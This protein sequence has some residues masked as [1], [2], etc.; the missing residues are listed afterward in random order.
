MKKQ[1]KWLAVVICFA[2]L[3]VGAIG[4][5]QWWQHTYVP[6]KIENLIIDSDVAFD[7]SNIRECV[8]AVDYLF[9][10][11]VEKA[12]D[13]MQTKT[14]REWPKYLVELDGPCTEYQLK[15]V[16]NI[17]GTLRQDEP[18]TY[19]QQ[20]GISA[21][22]SAVVVFGE[23]T[24]PKVGHYYLVWGTCGDFEMGEFIWGGNSWIE[25]EEGITSENL[26]NSKI[27]QAHVEAYK[28]EERNDIVQSIHNNY[29][30]YMSVHD[31]GYD[32][33]PNKVLPGSVSHEQSKRRIADDLKRARQAEQ[34]R[35][36]KKA[37]GIT[38]VDALN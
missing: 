33:T 12:W 9:V 25:L 16:K 2:V 26:K 32:G 38:G 35:Q 37:A 28:H 24:L 18:T 11:Y 23:G 10:G 30:R 7:R 34:A 6:G 22:R 4:G 17:K 15:V 13:F 27:Y 8:G 21:D 14:E 19:Y 1:I 5:F 3:A 20:G 29:A 31:V 36:A